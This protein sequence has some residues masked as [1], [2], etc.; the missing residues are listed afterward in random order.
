MNC[1]RGWGGE[2]LVLSGCPATPVTDLGWLVHLGCLSFLLFEMEIQTITKRMANR[3][4]FV[5]QL[6]LVRDILAE[7]SEVNTSREN[8]E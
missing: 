2:A 7:D 1:W 3:F 4:H 5:F 6:E 8:L